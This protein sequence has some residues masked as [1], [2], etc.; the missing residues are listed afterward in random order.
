MEGG[1]EMSETATPETDK[2]ED[3]D[4]MMEGEWH[5]IVPSSFARRLERERDEARR[6]C[7]EAQDGWSRALDERDDARKERDSA[8]KER[9]AV[10]NS[11]SKALDEAREELTR[12]RKEL[13]SA[14]RGAETNAKVNQGLCARLAEAERERDEARRERDELLQRLSVWESAGVKSVISTLMAYEMS[15][16]DRWT[17]QEIEQK[18]EA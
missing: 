5:W 1:S 7:N 14:N 11:W 8:L 2:A 15:A 17:L 4:P 9:D 16:K 12:V 3:Y 6:E 18:E 10:W 13:V